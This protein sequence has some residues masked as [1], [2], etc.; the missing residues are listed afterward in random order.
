METQRLAQNLM[1]QKQALKLSRTDVMMVNDVHKNNFQLPTQSKASSTQQLT[2][3]FAA[4][5]AS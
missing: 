1:P 3:Q 5:N 2:T 4:M